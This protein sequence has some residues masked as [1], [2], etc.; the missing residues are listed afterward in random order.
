MRGKIIKGIAGFYY[1]RVVESGVQTPT[2]LK[3]SSKLKPSIDA[4]FVYECKA[5]GIF[6]KDNT[7]PLV[8]DNVKIEILDEQ[9]KEG[10]IIEI[11][12]R[13][14]TLIRPAVANVDQAVVF[15]AVES[16]KPHLNLLDRFLVS[17]EVQKIP[18]LICFNKTDLDNKE[19]GKK[20][21]DIYKK[22]KYPVVFISVLKEENI[23]QLQKLLSGKTTVIAGPS[24]GGKSS[25][26]NHL[27]SEVH[28]EVGG[29]STKIARGKHT[30][31]HSQLI[32][33][34]EDSYIVD[35]PGFSSLCV[36]DLEKEDLKHHFPEFET[37]ASLCHFTGC[38]H[39]HEPNCGVKDALS[40]GLVSESR[41]K[42]Y[43]LLFRNKEEG[44]RTKVR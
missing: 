21:E 25:L 7:K 20:L 44:K 17:M 27:Q 8:G 31:R 36:E 39:L 23:E 13:K 32:A 33:I 38:N 11:L 9:D 35:T 14:N 1:V 12:P 34:G 28:M 43:H 10:N 6:R 19:E 4:G 30:T 18:T 2:A 22:T 16:P 41:V 24:G 26:I 15:F 40:K 42:S 5:K 37:F 3:P 29:L